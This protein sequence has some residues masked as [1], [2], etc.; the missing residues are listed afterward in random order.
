LANH[1][2]GSKIIVKRNT[3]E[4]KSGHCAVKMAGEHRNGRKRGSVPDAI[5]KDRPIPTRDTKH[6]IPPIQQKFNHANETASGAN[7]PLKSQHRKREYRTGNY[8]HG[9]RKLKFL[10]DPGGERTI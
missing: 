9:E 2:T 1:V 3:E 8:Q 6:L 5:V 7:A 4:V 10:D